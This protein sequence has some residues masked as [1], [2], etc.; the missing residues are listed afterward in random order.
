MAKSQAVTNIIKFGND[1]AYQI[2]SWTDRNGI[3]RFSFEVGIYWIDHKTNMP[4]IITRCD[5]YNYDDQTKARV[6]AR[7][8]LQKITEEAALRQPQVQMQVVPNQPV[9]PT[10]LPHHQPAQSTPAQDQ[11]QWSQP[12]P[13][14]HQS[15]P[16]QPL[17]PYPSTDEY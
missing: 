4:K 3:Q 5:L 1:T 17:A 7:R 10:A 9:Q 2:F 6:A 12:A 8:H 11:V 15:Q 14:S 13:T 16:L